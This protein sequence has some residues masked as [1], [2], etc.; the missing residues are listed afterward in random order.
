MASDPCG[1]YGTQLN[2][3]HVKILNT[4]IQDMIDGLN[5]FRGI[6]FVEISPET[7]KYHRQIESRKSASMHGNLAKT[8]MERLITPHHIPYEKDR[9]KL[10]NIIGQH[11]DQKQINIETLQQYL[12]AQFEKAIADYNSSSTNSGELC[13]LFLKLQTIM[14]RL[15]ILL[16]GG[17]W[18]HGSVPANYNGYLSSSYHYFSYFRLLC[19]I[20]NQHE[21][22]NYKSIIKFLAKSMFIQLTEVQIN[23]LLVF[24][25]KLKELRIELT[26]EKQK[27]MTAKLEEKRLK[28]ELNQLRQP[29][30]T[31][32]ASDLD[33]SGRRSRSSEQEEG[34]KRRRGSRSSEQEASPRIKSP[35]SPSDRFGQY[36][37]TVREYREKIKNLRSTYS[38]DMTGMQDHIINKAFGLLPSFFNRLFKSGYA[39]EH[40]TWITYIVVPDDDDDDDDDER[41]SMSKG[42]STINNKRNELRHTK[43]QNKQHRRH[44]KKQKKRHSRHTKK[45][46]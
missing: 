19:I 41:S 12:T 43:R 9:L 31:D 7:E 10:V 3:K 42:G 37:A 8:L 1:F 29:H 45:M 22:T 46:W 13:S 32:Y 35:I 21:G 34:R 16:A 2:A 26:K 5:N 25:E 23:E 24:I 44:T 33:I 30:R 4:Q 14:R 11:A 18:P 28:D 39:P 20:N 17:F 40:K 6:T 27:I 36:K 15:C 38:T